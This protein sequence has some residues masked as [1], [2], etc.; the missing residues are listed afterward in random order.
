MLKI[1]KETVLQ[2]E[3]KMD[4]PRLLPVDEIIIWRDGRCL[5]CGAPTYESGMSTPDP[6]G[7]KDCFDYCLWC[8]NPA[9]E[10]HRGECLGDMECPPEWANHDKF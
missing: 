10:H 7:D 8:S 6:I 5:K 2:K 3:P 4:D 9:C 1:K